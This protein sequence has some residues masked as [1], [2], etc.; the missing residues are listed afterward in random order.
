MGSQFARIAVAAGLVASTAIV[1]AD[2]RGTNERGIVVSVA[3]QADKP[4]T[5]LTAAD[6]TVRE[7]GVAREVVRVAPAPPPTHVV[8]LLD[9]SQATQALIPYVRP[10]VATFISMVAAQTPAPQ[11]MLMT[12][13]ERPTK[14]VDFTPNPEPL[15]DAAKRA[16]PVSGSGAYFLQAIT[17]AC[18]ELRKREAPSPVIVAFVA[19]GGPEFS[20]ELHAQIEEAL[21]GA[22]ASLWAVTLQQGAQ[23]TTSSA[24]RERS[25]V[26]GDV[27]TNS[28]GMNKV[29]LSGQGIESAFR[30]VTSLIMS[31]LVVFYGRPDALIPP[32]RVEVTSRRAGVRVRA[33]RWA[34]K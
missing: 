15:L 25:A 20:S 22:G 27:T 3:G 21:R 30:T 2:Q 34:G 31:R 14:R 7:N 13:G 26:L 10:A 1:F 19:E 4:V 23:N 28:G 12:F 5:D 32:D 16:F 24:A 6:F 9:D 29:V 17:D 11:Q 8:L 18:R 33:A